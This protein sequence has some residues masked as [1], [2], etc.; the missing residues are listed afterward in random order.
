MRKPNVLFVMTDQQRWDTIAALGNGIIR[1]PNMDRL[2]RRGVACTNAYTTCPVCLPARYTIR[3]GREPARTGVFNNP[4]SVHQSATMEARCGTFLARQMGQ[5]GYRTFGIG[6][7]HTRPWDQDVGFETQLHSEELY[8]DAR[9]RQGDAFARFIRTQHP[10]YDWIDMLQGERAEMYYVPQMSPLPEALTVESWAADRAVEQ[11]ARRAADPRPYFGFVSFIGPHPPCAP[12][13]PYNRLYNPDLMPNPVRGDP[14][15]DHAD[16]NIP[17]N[18][19]LVWA[20]DI[21]DSWAR[22]IKARY[23]GEITFIDDCLGRILDAVEARPDADNTL[24]CLFTD[25]GDMLG[26]HHAWQKE[27]FFEASCRIPLLLSWPEQLPGNARCAELACLTDL[28]GVATTAAGAPELRDGSDLLGLLAGRASPRRE[29]VGQYGTP[30]TPMFRAMVRS[31]PWKYIFMANGGREQLFNLVSDPG[32]TTNCV[33]DNPRL[34]Q[35]F[36]EAAA[37]SIDTPLGRPAL[38]NNSLRAF[39]FATRL[40]ERI[41][42]FDLARGITDFGPTPSDPSTTAGCALP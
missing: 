26:D 27:C 41:L 6:K 20:E 17:W 18:N 31:G 22:R 38:Q 2:V 29:L 32:V 34:V 10:E 24:I 19:H 1:T 21:N 37:R 42:Q 23:Y 30:G 28:F 14:G 16:E 36:R 39:P 25:H 7:F 8:E 12:P 11:L 5:L 15:V 33:A 13:Q 35:Q 3:T 9:Q 4:D 40:R